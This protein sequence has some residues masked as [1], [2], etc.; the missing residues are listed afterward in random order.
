MTLVTIIHYADHLPKLICPGNSRVMKERKG[1]RKKE[2]TK[3]RV[4]HYMGLSIYRR[5]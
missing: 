5:L 3:G 2:E 4:D 1:D